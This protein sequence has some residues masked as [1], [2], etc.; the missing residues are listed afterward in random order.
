MLPGIDIVINKRD[1]QSAADILIAWFPDKTSFSISTVFP[2]IQ[3]EKIWGEWEQ[4]QSKI[5]RKRDINKGF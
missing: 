4:L 5:V 1:L 3:S 2:H